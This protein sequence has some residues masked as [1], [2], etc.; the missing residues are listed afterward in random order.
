[1]FGDGPEKTVRYFPD[2]LPIG[3]QPHAD[4]HVFVYLVTRPS[5]MDF[6]LFLLRH[7]PLLRVL[8]RWT[9]R[10][11]LPR[12]LV[13]GQTGLPARRPGAPRDTIAPLGGGDVGVAV[14]RT[15]AARRTGRRA[16]RPPLPRRLRRLPHAAISRA[17]PT[18]VRRSP[19]HALDGRLAHRGRRHRPRTRTSRVRRARLGSTCISLP[20]LTS[21]EIN[22]RG[23]PRGRPRKMRSSP[24]ASEKFP[25]AVLRR[26]TDPQRRPDN[27]SLAASS[28]VRA[29]HSARWAALFAARCAGT[30][31]AIR[32]GNHGVSDPGARAGD[33]PA[34]VRRGRS[35]HG[36]QC[37]RRCR[38]NAS[39]RPQQ[40]RV[41]GTMW[42]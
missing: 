35:R 3:M 31:A 36:C 25:Q 7:V 16:C 22:S 13:E 10:L 32:A 17:L 11:L 14:P 19:D 15:E 9:V 39:P 1:M 42:R 2:K 27:Y 34:R 18:V 21:P 5:P 20:W 28:I 24:N 29:R 8:F 6:R 33:G 4:T 37:L 26:A 30:G 40:C 23:R 41:L 38:M 12:K